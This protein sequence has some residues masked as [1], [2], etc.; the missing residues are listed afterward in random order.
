MCHVG[1]ATLVAT[2]YLVKMKYVQKL[3]GRKKA[4]DKDNGGSDHDESENE[5]KK[6]RGSN[7]PKQYA[8]HL[9]ELVEQSSLLKH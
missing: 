1:G 4:S 2:P 9:Q 3:F 6:G 7:L 8:K 5:A